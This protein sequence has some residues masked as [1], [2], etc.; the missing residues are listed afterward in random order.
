MGS[1]PGA[2]G[3]EPTT[4][5]SRG[6]EIAWPQKGHALEKSVDGEKRIG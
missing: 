5:G 1:S 2:D 4:Q 6:D 3:R